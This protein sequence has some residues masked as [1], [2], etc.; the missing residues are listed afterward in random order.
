MLWQEDDDKQEFVVPDDIVDLSFRIDCKQ[1]ALDHAH[2]LSQALHQALPWLADE[3]DAGVH[4]IHGASSGNGWIRPDESCGEDFIYLSKRARMRLRVPKARI[5]D[6]HGLIGQIL[7][8]G[9]YPV[10]VGKAEIKPLTTLG[11]LFARY[12]ALLDGEDEEAFLA[13]IVEEIRAL[14]I[15][16]KKVLCGVGHSFRMPEGRVETLSVMVAD[17]DP[18]AS[19]TLQQ[20]GVGAGR[21]HGFGLFIPHKGIK[22]VGDLSEKSHFSGT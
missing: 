12:I 7:Q 22:P 16:V 4:L 13:R 21:K 9:D 5:D 8:V 14:E 11:T 18:R 15:K 10:R 20:K 17:L 19:V 1:I 6:A 3:D 2:D